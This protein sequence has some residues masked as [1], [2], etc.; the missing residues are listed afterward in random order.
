MKFVARAPAVVEAVQWQ[1]RLADL[2]AEPWVAA[3]IA[4]GHIRTERNMTGSTVYV[5]TID[6]MTRAL[7]GEWIVQGADGRFAVLSSE[8]MAAAYRWP[9]AETEASA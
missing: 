7:R 4:D 5:L 9:T 3:A 8:E 1:G 2:I 6:G